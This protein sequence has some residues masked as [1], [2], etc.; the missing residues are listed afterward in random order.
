MIA[1]I[2][3]VNACD[4]NI[5]RV[6]SLNNTVQHLYHHDH[7]ILQKNYGRVHGQTWLYNHPVIKCK[8]KPTVPCMRRVF[9][10]G[11]VS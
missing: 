8:F 4:M 2:T 7:Q 11:N 5:P 9:L 3:S 1:V 6:S 10:C